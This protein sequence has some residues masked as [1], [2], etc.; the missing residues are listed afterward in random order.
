MIAVLKM[1]IP[2]KITFNNITDSQRS[3]SRRIGGT[4][5]IV[6]MRL[7][8]GWTIKDALTVPVTTEKDEKWRFKSRRKM[9]VA[10]CRKLAMS[11]KWK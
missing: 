9:S 5:R 4:D 8:R 6:G 1:S 3:W 7:K 11:G 10:D 2:A